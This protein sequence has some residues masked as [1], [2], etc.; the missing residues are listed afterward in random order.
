[1]AAY[2]NSEEQVKGHGFSR[3]LGAAFESVPLHK[4]V[5]KSRR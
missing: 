2:P 5:C 3:S 1:M 4:S